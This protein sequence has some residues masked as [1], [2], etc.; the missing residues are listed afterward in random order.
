AEQI[1]RLLVEGE[2]G[3]W[4]PETELLLF[5]AAR[6]DHVERAVRPALARGA[7][8]VCDRYV[9]STRAYQGAGA[10]ERRVMV[11]RLHALAI[12]LD[13]DLTLILDMDPATGLERAKSR[14]GDEERFEDFGLDMQ[15]RIRA[16]FLDIAQEFPDRCRV[17]DGNRPAEDVSAEIRALVTRALA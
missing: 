4:S 12:G 5:T 3:R 8:V 2:P 6:R 1:R 10:P 7:V 11:D 13:P 14:G 9:D 17:I 15:R 16:G